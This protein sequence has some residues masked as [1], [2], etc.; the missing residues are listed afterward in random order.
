[1]RE[2][3]KRYCPPE[4]H[5]HLRHCLSYTTSDLTGELFKTSWI[6]DKLTSNVA[7]LNCNAMLTFQ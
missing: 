4:I 1:M 5:I 2:H 6:E 3:F 7:S